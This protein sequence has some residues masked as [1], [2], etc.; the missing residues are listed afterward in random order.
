MI[1]ENDLH[2][3]LIIQ[4]MGT[5]CSS[6]SDSRMRR[7]GQENGSCRGQR[8]FSNLEKPVLRAPATLHLSAAASSPRNSW[9]R[10][11][12]TPVH[13]GYSS[14]QRQGSRHSQGTRRPRLNNTGRDLNRKQEEGKEPYKGLGQRLGTVCSRA[15]GGLISH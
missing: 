12:S 4:R 15:T 7:S 6:F 10:P 1:L 11:P 9:N 5:S 3:K 8:Q 2:G 14:L 13:P